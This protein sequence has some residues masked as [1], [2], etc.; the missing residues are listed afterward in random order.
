M[1][2][3]GP[4]SQPPAVP[5][6]LQAN[7]PRH[8]AEPERFLVSDLCAILETYLEPSEVK[9]I[10]RAYLFSADAHQGQDRAS[11]EPYIFHP[12]AVARI[13]AEMHMDRESITAA[14]LHDVIEDTAVAR[15][16]IATQ[17]GEEVAS[18]VDGVSKLTH[19]EFESRA[20][21]QAANF[22]KMML[23]M[24]SDLR[25]ILVKLADRLHNMRTLSALR[26]KKRR[27]IA[28]ET[29]EIYVP[30]AQRLGMRGIRREL[31]QTGFEALYPT[32]FQVITEAV[33][34]VKGQRKEL[35][36][37]LEATI[38]QRMEEKEIQARIQGR[39]KNLW[40][41]YR[42]MREKSLS[43]SE[44]FDVFAIRIVV[45]DIDT[46]YRTL[47]ALH[48]LYKPVPG[49]F[50]DYIAIP[51]SNGYQ[52]LH[53]ILFGP[54]GIP[55]EI[56]I[57]TVAMDRVA[58][59]GI[60]AHWHY[61]SGDEYSSAAQRRAHEWMRSV[62]DLQQNTGNA[63][64]FLENV[65]V[66]LFPD[67]VYIFTPRGEIMELPRGATGVDFAYAVHTDIGNSCVAI[68]IDR[69]LSPLSTPL[70]SGQT[71]EVITAKNAFPR[72]VWLNYAV[73]ARARHNIR[74]YL[75]N[76]KESEAI[77]QGRL[78]LRKALG[79]QGVDALNLDED[80]LKQLLDQLGYE[81]VDHLYRDIG[82]GDRLAALVARELIDT[83][84]T[85]AGSIGDKPV[86]IR[87]VGGT[88]LNFA[89]CCTPIPGDPIVGMMSAGRGMAVHRNDCSNLRGI[90]ETS[91]ILSVA[92]SA[93]LD[94]DYPAGIK[95]VTKSRRGVLAR[96]AT[97]ISEQSGDI[98]N[99]SFV[100]RDAISTGI[101]FTVKVKNRSHLADIIRQLRSIP[102]V[103]KV[104]R[105]MS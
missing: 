32:R 68:K 84:D 30:I 14:I 91:D 31:E 46:C 95:V 99:V 50:K 58:E 73:T 11:G 78:L 7:V 103:V 89:N 10:Y 42:K 9:Q 92:W 8:A 45:D 75:K 15:E 66:D 74:H 60:A 101:E 70:Q 64:E 61:K 37:K 16:Q 38:V 27:R 43:F 40:S 100:E 13:L 96:I 35:M 34:R 93:D 86:S 69:Q 81:V 98:A 76:L 48:T 22:R 53:T 104:S 26:P 63:L 19:L 28:H 23:A 36:R 2:A 57:R 1:S 20:E 39:E 25:V 62:M 41:I 72:S 83:S 29:L 85:L 33:K 65:K 44:V 56:Q 47:G 21:A 24:A 52:S 6:A 90:A 17:F 4:N 5:D 87:G 54:H 49:R 80:R 59:T 82:M 71:V 67:E 102:E 77:E 55:V 3:I 88:V 94:G 51:K 79:D 18:L 105:K 12:L 97:A